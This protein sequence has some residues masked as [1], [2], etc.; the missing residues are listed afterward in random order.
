MSKE[1]KI[2]FN[3]IDVL[4]LLCFV[5]LIGGFAFYATGNW[6]TNSNTTKTQPNHVVRYVLTAENVAPEVANAVKEGDV[7]KDSAKE[8]VKGEIVQIISNEKYV[9]KLYNAEKGVYEEAEHPQNR[10]IVVA[11]ESDYVLNGKTA[12]IDDAEI[13]VGK[14]VNYKTSE[15]AI[16]GY[17]TE[18]KKI[19]K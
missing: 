13:K 2:H 11:I 8:T 16:D 14:S 4:I 5:V 3:F 12:M 10:T 9:K 6:Q 19:E 18:V 7:V 15:Y 1:K 17:I